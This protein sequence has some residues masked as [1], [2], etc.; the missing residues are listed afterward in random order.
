M[1]VPVRR[2][3]SY[4]DG[5]NE[6]RISIYPAVPCLLGYGILYGRVG[7]NPLFGVQFPNRL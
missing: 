3:G 6:A 5:R 4:P 2:I 1:I 7:R